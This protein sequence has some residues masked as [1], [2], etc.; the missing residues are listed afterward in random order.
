MN[1]DDC[2][3][4]CHVLAA[5][6]SRCN[7]PC[8]AF[9]CA[10]CRIPGVTHLSCPASR[11]AKHLSTTMRILRQSD[12][13]SRTLFPLPR[14]P[15]LRLLCPSVC[16]IRVSGDSRTVTPQG[17]E[18]VGTAPTS[19]RQILSDRR[20]YEYGY[21]G[22]FATADREPHR[23]AVAGALRGRPSLHVWERQKS[24]DTINEGK[25]CALL[26]TCA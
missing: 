26:R 15:F 12:T 4:G 14:P 16:L 24:R 11:S 23:S 8:H 21:A 1:R 20:R 7:K 13:V 19:V 25:A 22:G 9:A 2:M 17:E 3:K 18:V 6:R 5:A 10:S